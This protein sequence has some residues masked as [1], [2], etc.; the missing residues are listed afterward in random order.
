MRTFSI[1]RTL[2]KTR[3][4][5]D[6]AMYCP[7]CSAQNSE[8]GK[9]CRSCGQELS[10]VALAMTGEVV[11]DDRHGRRARRRRF[12]SREAKIQNG[13]RHSFIGVGLLV[14]GFILMITRQTWGI[15]LIFASFV[16]LGRGV[17]ELL[18]A[19]ALPLRTTLPQPPA[20]RTGEIT[21][22]PYDPTAL[23]SPPSVTEGTTRMMDSQREGP[24]NA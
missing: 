14:A 17:G 3:K 12:Q 1:T 20:R 22:P 15:W 2:L 16:M 6:Q 21:P 11:E 13:I 4:R 10:T 23:P 19:K 18:S 7:W 9:F 5:G 8:G 24:E